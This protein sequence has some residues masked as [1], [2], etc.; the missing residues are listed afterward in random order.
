MPSTPLLLL[1]EGPSHLTLLFSPQPPSC[2]PRT[3]V[4]GGRR[5]P[6]RAGDQPGR[7]AGSLGPSGRGKC[8][9]LLSCSSRMAPPTCLSLSPR[10]Q[11]CR[12]C[13][14]STSPPPSVPHVLPV[15]LGVP[16]VS[17]GVRVPHQRPA[18]IL[19]LGRC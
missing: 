5:G 12:S 2:A 10:P 11:G 6:C 13:L 19:I 3:N 16:P 17:L 14:A 1:L 9:P 15:H 8:P 4:A 7:S 18:G